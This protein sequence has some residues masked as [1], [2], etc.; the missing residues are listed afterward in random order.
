[1]F[2]WT[3]SKVKNFEYKFESKNVKNSEHNFDQ[4]VLVGGKIGR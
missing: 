4:N 2:V 3:V 1:M